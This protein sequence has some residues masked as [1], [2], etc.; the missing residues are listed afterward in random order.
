MSISPS[1]ALSRTDEGS[2]PVEGFRNVA[3]IAHVDH[4]ETTLVDA[5]LGQAG[6]MSAHHKP[7]ESD[8]AD[9]HATRVMDSMDQ[10][11]ERGITILA[12]NTAVRWP[13]SAEHGGGKAGE[14]KLNIVDTPGHAD[15]GGEVER[16]LTMVDGVLLLVDSSEGPLPQTRFVLRKALELDLPA[17]VVVN[18]VDRPDARVAEVVSEVEELFLDLEAEM[19][20]LEFPIVYTNAK[21][22]TASLDPTTQEDS[23]EPLVRTLVD[24][25]PPPSHD[26]D[27]P[28]RA[29]VTN[30]DS[31]PFVGRLALCRVVSGTIKKNQPVAWCKADGT[32]VSARTG[33][34]FV[35]ENHERVEVDS[36]GPGEL[37]AV[38]GIENINLGETIADPDDPRPLP[39]IT[40]DEPSL[41]MTIGINTSPMAGKE[42]SKLTARLVK[43]RLDTELLG[44][45]SLRVLPTEAPNAWEV[46]AR[47]ELQLAVLIEAMRREGFEL[48]VGKPQVLIKEIDGVRQEPFERLT[49]DVPEEFSGTVTQLLSERRGRMNEVSH[50]DSGWVRQEWIVPA[51]GL[52][53][54]RTKFLTET[55]G[56]GVLNHVFEGY[57]K[58][59]GKIR[60]RGTGSIVAD[61]RGPT[62][63]NAIVAIQERSAL[64]VPPGVEVYEGMVVGENS[65]PDDM[66]VNICKEK[67]QTNMRASGSDNTE[68]V[69]PPMP[70]GLDRALEFIATDECVEVTPES[71]RLRKVELDPNIRARAAKKA[72]ADA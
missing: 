58:W 11:R 8:A 68:K 21:A 53:G 9:G 42:G 41:S 38:S 25:L 14:V 40:V 43:N 70:M 2:V 51:R 60:S 4:G 50:G 71:I 66:D 10:E 49:V 30:L 27:A 69:T 63:M 17:V 56:T 61:R 23:L 19:H 65:R 59:A 22:G 16:A 44:N 72:K 64:I 54:F 13:L 28:L 5:L 47:G 37:V 48:T 35:T 57:E 55:R 12:K 67:K 24:H 26:P 3:I 7:D 31:N 62:T 15:F 46:Q 36:A 1:P 6:A 29:W 34:V 18:K 39:V 52:I 33:S 32:I 45:V 20:H